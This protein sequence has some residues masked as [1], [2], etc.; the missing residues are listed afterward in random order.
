MSKISKY[1]KL[2]EQ[3]FIEDSDV[4]QGIDPKSP[5]G[6]VVN[7][8]YY[9]IKDKNPSAA[10]NFVQQAR[11][12]KDMA[13][14]NQLKDKFYK[15]YG[16]KDI[17][18]IYEDYAGFDTSKNHKFPTDAIYDEE[19]PEYN[20]VSEEIRYYITV[21]DELYGNLRKTLEEMGI[22][23]W[24]A[25]SEETETGYIK[26][27][28]A[29]NGLRDKR[30]KRHEMIV[31]VFRSQLWSMPTEQLAQKIVKEVNYRNPEILESIL[32]E[33]KKIDRICQIDSRYSDTYLY[34]GLKGEEYGIYADKRVKKFNGYAWDYS[35][36]SPAFTSKE[37]ALDWAKGYLTR[38]AT[39]E[40]VKEMYQEGIFKVFDDDFKQVLNLEG[41]GGKH[42]ISIWPKS[43]SK[44]IDPLPKYM[45]MGNGPA[46]NV[47]RINH[48]KAT[49]RPSEYEN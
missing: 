2:L 7:N 38:K 44:G 33:L 27:L 1:I 32:P 17:D 35:L 13:S 18:D 25:D 23:I 8:A 14:L 29:K 31:D 39:L 4:L 41:E 30:K 42:T 43:G 47:E 28:V 12:L 5:G 16:A 21:T 22:R 49:G 36:I 45:T 46:R 26:I 15:Q 37:E 20:N 40:D 9:S 6:A 48:I 10:Q 19:H 11:Q 24:R 3:E 34:L